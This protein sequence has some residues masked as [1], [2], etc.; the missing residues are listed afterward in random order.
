MDETPITMREHP[1]AKRAHR[2]GVPRVGAG[3]DF[4]PLGLTRVTT[5]LA[6]RSMRRRGPRTTVRRPRRCMQLAGAAARA[7]ERHH[8]AP[9]VDVKDPH[10]VLRAL[11][12]DR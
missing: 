4:S 6:L 12:L 10:L 5:S 7:A 8:T 1:G 9:R 3:D 11:Q 2:G